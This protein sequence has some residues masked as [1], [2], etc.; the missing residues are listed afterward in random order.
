MFKAGLHAP[1]IPLSDV[2]G[3]AAKASPEQIAAAGLKVGVT[4]AA[5]VISSVVV[6]VA[7]CPVAGVN[8]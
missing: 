6:A 7:H 3:K 2:V 4:D 8:V 5:I 1:V